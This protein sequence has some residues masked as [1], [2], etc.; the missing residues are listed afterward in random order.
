MSCGTH[1]PSDGKVEYSRVK[2]VFVVHISSIF[3]ISIYI[4]ISHFVCCPAESNSMATSLK[5]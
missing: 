3:G 1:L 5:I 4:V 2:R